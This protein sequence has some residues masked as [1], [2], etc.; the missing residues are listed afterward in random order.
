MSADWLAR[1]E[2][3]AADGE[4]DLVVL[5]GGQKEMTHAR[6]WRGRVLVD[7]EADDAAGG[8][9]LRPELLRRLVAL[10][11]DVR[12]HADRVELRAPGRVLEA[13]SAE[14]R[15][16]VAG[17]GGP[18]RVQFRATLRF[19]DGRYMGGEEV[20]SV[21]TDVLLRLTARVRSGSPRTSRGPR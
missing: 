20:Y 10:H 5:L 2:L 15:E 17:V 6:L 8:C 3:A 1:V 19:R 18:A 11:A 16:L 13:V 9:L 12:Q 4:A 7:W 21:G 14:H